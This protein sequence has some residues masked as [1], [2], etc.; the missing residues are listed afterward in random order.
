M[1]RRSVATDILAEN[2]G[3]DWLPV[4]PGLYS[5]SVQG[6]FSATIYLQRSFDAGLTSEDVTSFGAA[7]AEN[8]EAAEHQHVRLFCKTGGF[9]SGRA[10]CRLGQYAR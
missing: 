6:S 5:V 8:A 3:T 7:V 2:T 10:G 4:D 1:A 9:T